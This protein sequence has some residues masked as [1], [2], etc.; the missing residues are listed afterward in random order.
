M[1]KTFFYVKNVFLIKILFFVKN[2][3]EVRF[4]AHFWGPFL[5]HFWVHFWSKNRSKIVKF[6]APGSGSGPGRKNGAPIFFNY[7]REK[8][9]M[10]YRTENWGGFCQK[11]ENWKIEPKS[12]IK[13][14]KNRKKGYIPPK[15]LFFT[16]K[17]DFLTHF[18]PI[19]DPFW[20][21]FDPKNGSKNGSEFLIGFWSKKWPIF[22]VILTSSFFVMC[23]EKKVF[24]I[25]KSIIFLFFSKFLQLF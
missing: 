24:L 21:I 7:L 3:F 17:I 22:G 18:W 6:L 15:S 12:R 20:V 11:R 25:K 16:P 1:K 23:D 2:R 19:F 13:N 5:V 10:G 4:P 9:E 8:A 14:G